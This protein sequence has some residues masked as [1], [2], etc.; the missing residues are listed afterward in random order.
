MFVS[1]HLTC[2]PEAL[3]PKAREVYKKV[4]A[5]IETEVLPVEEEITE[6]HSGDKQWTVHPKIEELKVKCIAL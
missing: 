3:S 4:K 2:V 1:G 6:Y 5:F